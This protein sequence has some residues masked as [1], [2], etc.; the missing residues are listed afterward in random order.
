M[1][2]ELSELGKTQTDQLVRTVAYSTNQVTKLHKDVMDIS[3]VLQTAV[4]NGGGG[5][6]CNTVANTTVSHVTTP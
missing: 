3:N 4:N 2:E 6:A 5:G 1:F